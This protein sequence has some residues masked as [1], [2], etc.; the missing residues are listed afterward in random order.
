MKFRDPNLKETEFPFF[1]K[2]YPHLP[3]PYIFGS[4]GWVSLPDILA[5][6]G[7]KGSKYMGN[8]KIRV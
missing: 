4:R 8:W 3:V 6:L 2:V 5:C 7:A 1:E